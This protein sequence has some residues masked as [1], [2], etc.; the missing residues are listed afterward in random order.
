MERGMAHKS[1]AQNATDPFQKLYAYEEASKMFTRVLEVK[2][3]PEA[4]AAFN[5]CCAAMNVEYQRMKQVKRQTKALNP[6]APMTKIGDFNT[7]RTP[8]VQGVL[9]NA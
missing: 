8:W 6:D 5:E 4:R 7:K 9:R 1:A 2:Q 3:L